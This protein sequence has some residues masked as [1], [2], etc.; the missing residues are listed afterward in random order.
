M[1]TGWVR[2][3]GR[4]LGGEG[5]MEVSPN[6][7]LTDSLPRLL[8]ERGVLADCPVASAGGGRAGG[9]A[10][11]R[12]PRRQAR[13]FPGPVGAS[14]ARAGADG[15]G[16]AGAAGPSRRAVHHVRA[17]A[18]G[19]AVGGGAYVWTNQSAGAQRSRSYT[20]RRKLQ[21]EHREERAIPNKD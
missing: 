18:Q 4:G 21:L 20:D 3:L 12:G 2:S 8:Q 16:T 7:A 15:A 13:R 6:I 5:P 19:R 14:P 17:K 10:A 9:P 1:G 11:A